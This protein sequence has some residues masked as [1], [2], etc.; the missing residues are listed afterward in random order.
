M[1]WNTYKDTFRRWSRY[2]RR[3]GPRIT[4]QYAAQRGNLSIRSR[5]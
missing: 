4:L 3:L 2:M 5:Q 1:N